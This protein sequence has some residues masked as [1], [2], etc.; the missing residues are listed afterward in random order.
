MEA[1]SRI[2]LEYSS[3][4]R[5]VGK[6]DRKRNLKLNKDFYL[7]YLPIC[8]YFV[9]RPYWI[10]SYKETFSEF[11]HMGL[12]EYCFENYRFPNYQSD[13]LFNGCHHIFSQE[14]YVIREWLIPGMFNLF[15]FLSFF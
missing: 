4:W 8:L 6:F 3:S 13:H 12:W 10:Q 2:V 14:Y 5:F 11:K 9:F 1:F 15:L 7:A